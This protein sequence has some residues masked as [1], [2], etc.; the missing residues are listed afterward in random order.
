MAISMNGGRLYPT[1]LLDVLTGVQNVGPDDA[2]RYAPVADGLEQPATGSD[3][4]SSLLA[5]LYNVRTPSQRVIYQQAP[6]NLLG[7]L[8]IQD[9]QQSDAQKERQARSAR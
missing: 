3:P 7:Q 8:L 1:T 6:D 9:Q 2:P 4:T 5:A